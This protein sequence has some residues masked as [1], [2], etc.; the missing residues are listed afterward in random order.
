MC[1]T[2]MLGTSMTLIILDR[3]LVQFSDWP[4]SEMSIK[5]ALK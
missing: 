1:L 3:R 2:N 5:K 4:V